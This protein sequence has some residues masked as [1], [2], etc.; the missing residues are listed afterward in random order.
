MGQFQDYDGNRTGKG[1]MERLLPK[2]AEGAT[3]DL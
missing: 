3:S 2:N 1:K